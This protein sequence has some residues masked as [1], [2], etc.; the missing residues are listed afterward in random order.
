[1]TTKDPTG[2]AMPEIFTDP[3]DLNL[4]V[5]APP[6]PD[7]PV[8]EL[9]VLLELNALLTQLAALHLVAIAK[10]ADMADVI[11]QSEFLRKANELLTM[12]TSQLQVPRAL[13]SGPHP[14]GFAC[15]TCKRKTPNPDAQHVRHADGSVEYHQIY[16]SLE[17]RVCAACKAASETRNAAASSSSRCSAGDAGDAGDP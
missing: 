12:R 8:S 16:T 5:T 7:P 10:G 4:S 15:P 1:M 3:P 6:S 11:E 9:D 13:R 2:R 17:F 14:Q